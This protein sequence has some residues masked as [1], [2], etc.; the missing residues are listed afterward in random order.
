[1]VS[2]FIFCTLRRITFVGQTEAFW[3]AAEIEVQYDSDI[4][5]GLLIGVG[6]THLFVSNVPST[7]MLTCLCVD[8]NDIPRL[9]QSLHTAMALYHSAVCKTNYFSRTTDS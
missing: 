6:R 1:M 3:P 8:S 5:G 9:N 4:V 2:M 7:V